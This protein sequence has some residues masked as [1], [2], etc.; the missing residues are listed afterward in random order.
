MKPAVRAMRARGVVHEPPVRDCVARGRQRLC[1]SLLRAR[2]HGRGQRVLLPKPEMPEWFDRLRY[3]PPDTRL[4][5][6]YT[7]PPLPP[8]VANVYEFSNERQS[9]P[10]ADVIVSTRLWPFRAKSS[11]PVWALS[12]PH[13]TTDHRA[14]GSYA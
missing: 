1:G 7:P 5:T 3:D 9:V 11:D 8:P 4:D 13:N 12:R 10:K 6:T 2:L 14:E